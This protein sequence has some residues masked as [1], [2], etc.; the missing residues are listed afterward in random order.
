MCTLKYHCDLPQ[1]VYVLARLVKASDD[2]K[3]VTFA[4]IENKLPYLHRYS[5][6]GNYNVKG[7]LPT[8]YPRIIMPYL[9]F[10]LATKDR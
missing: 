9:Y 5:V 8:H 4:A 1:C 3:D 2:Y 7:I 10:K 6:T